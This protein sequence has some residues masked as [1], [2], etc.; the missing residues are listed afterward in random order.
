MLDQQAPVT[1]TTFS[2]VAGTNV[3]RWKNPAGFSASWGVQIGATGIPQS[4]VLLLSGLTPGGTAGSFT[5]N[6]AYEHPTET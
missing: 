1:Y 6:T 5:G 3:L 2:E 4:E